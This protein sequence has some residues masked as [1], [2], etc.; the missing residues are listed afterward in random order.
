MTKK[1]ILSAIAFVGVI[2]LLELIILM[3][4]GIAEPIG[5]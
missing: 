2:W 5:G 3:M 4:F 1:D